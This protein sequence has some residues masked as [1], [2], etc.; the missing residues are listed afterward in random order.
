[1]RPPQQ[2][3]SVPSFVF[4]LTAQAQGA[5]IKTDIKRIPEA[6]ARDS[7]WSETQTSQTPTHIWRVNSTG[8]RTQR[9]NS[10]SKRLSTRHRSNSLSTLDQYAGDRSVAPGAFKVDIDRPHPLAKTFGQKSF[11]TLEVP[12]PHYRLGTPRFSA[13]GTA[14]LHSSIYTRASTDDV[15]SSVFSGADFDKIFPVPP[16]MEPRRV[17]S[18][19]HSHTSPQPYAVRIA[20]VRAESDDPAPLPTVGFDPRKEPIVPAIFDELAANK[21]DVSIVRYSPTTGDITAAS[22]AR[23]IAQVTSENFLDYELLSDFFLTVRSYLSTHDLLAYLVARFEWAINK[24]DDDGRVIR[25]RAF[26]ALRHWILNYFPYDFVVDRELRIQFCMYL[27]KLSEEIRKRSIYGASDLKLILDLKRCWNGRCALYWDCAIFDGDSRYDVDIVPGGIAGSRNSEL[28]HPSQLRTM[29]IDTTPPK[30]GDEIGQDNSA[31]T[32]DNWFDAVMEA[33]DTE[34]HMHKRQV[35]GTTVRSLPISPSSEQSIQVLSCSIPAKGLK[36]TMMTPNRAFGAHPVPATSPNHRI[37]PAAPSAIYTEK[38]ARPKHTH[39]RSGS[40][41]DAL[42]DHRAPL[43]SSKGEQSDNLLVTAFPYAGSMIR[44]NV[45]PPGQPY[46]DICAP[47]TPSIELRNVYFQ[48]EDSDS[49]YADTTTKPHGLNA[50]GV[51]NILGSI[52]RALSSKQSGSHHSSNAGAKVP[53]PHQIESRRVLGLPA[54]QKCYCGEER[55]HESYKNKGRADLLAAD[56]AE[57]FQRACNGDLGEDLQ[58]LRD[59]EISPGNERERHPS[60]VLPVPD[61]PPANSQRK[62]SAVTLGSQ[63]IPIVDDTGSDRPPMPSISRNYVTGGNTHAVEPNPYVMATSLSPETSAAIVSR[64]FQAEVQHDERRP[65]NNSIH[66]VSSGQIVYL[67]KSET[68]GQ[69]SNGKER[70]VTKPP[71]HRPGPSTGSHGRSFR[72]TRSASTSLRRYASFQS[73]MTKH[74]PNYSFSAASPADSAARFSNAISDSPPT[75][76]LRRR[77]GGDLRA[78]QNVHDLEQLLRPRSTGSMTTYTDS[79]IG[80]GLYITKRSTARDVSAYGSSQILRSVPPEYVLATSQ[81]APSLVRTHSSQPAL[82]PSFEAAVAEFARIPDD[83]EGGIEATLLKLEGKYEKLL[84]E[85]NVASSGESTGMEGNSH[86]MRE[87]QEQQN[88][89]ELRHQY[90]QVADPTDSNF[91]EISRGGMIG[92]STLPENQEVPASSRS[93]SQNMS[94][95]APSVYAESDESYNSIPLL[96]RGLSGRST[97]RGRI[98]QNGH[99]GFVPQRLTTSNRNSV[100]DALE[101]SKLSIEHDSV[102]RFRHGSSAPTATTDSFLLDEDED[103]SDLS[104]E[105]SG[106]DAELEQIVYQVPASPTHN[107]SDLLV[108]TTEINHRP[109]G[110]PPSPPMTTENALEIKAQAH[111]TQEDRKPPTPNP[112]PITQTA[113]PILDSAPVAYNQTTMLPS[114][115]GYANINSPRTSQHMC[116]ILA[117]ASETLAEQFTIIEKDALNEIDWRDLVDMRWHHKSL[118]ILNWV[119][120]LRTQ[121]PTGIDLVTARFN[122]IVKWA[123]SEIIMTQNIEERASTIVKYI[124]VAQQCRKVHNYATLLQLT[125]ALTSFDCSRLTKT[126]ARVPAAEKKTLQD[127]ES[128]VTPMRNFHNLRKEMETANAEEG[129]IPVVGMWPRSASGSW[130]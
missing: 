72:S 84:A 43:P 47:I 37:G 60:D 35:S 55:E 8:R 103:L 28:S 13:R 92:M 107:F 2:R 3:P 42:R 71:A 95:L 91:L 5:T 49:S 81:K 89:E 54:N 82:R 117:Y 1:M 41:S 68:M 33:G 20:P 48:S 123:L 105:M 100:S 86:P 112:S 76:M 122:I 63:S 94:R 58:R 53:S 93:N 22:P 30:Q 51:K 21:H 77:P 29:L 31:S 26:A 52:R 116:F 85:S 62:Q 109:L 121:D 18:R 46:V 32:L 70:P 39:K 113:E 61:S 59:A 115:T 120:Y 90:N 10:T 129:C 128:L 45:F 111:Q 56:V 74:V 75:R 27:N 130:V 98:E 96:E 65:R 14:F 106:D 80:S 114:N 15:R 102:L 24:F 108:P 50:P 9:S 119:E 57:S 6:K 104:S 73:G 79:V 125:I 4:P 127:L 36:R 87:H 16:G 11:P 44:G 99:K 110:Y 67:P 88:S 40:F 126:W 97:R 19:R 83:E 7:S 34:P 118:Q 69:L 38:Q 78:N 101:S 23:I 64:V 12:I 66:S 17:P 25:V 124:H